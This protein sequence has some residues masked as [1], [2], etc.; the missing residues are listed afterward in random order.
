MAVAAL[1]GDGPGGPVMVT[2][3]SSFVPSVTER[4]KEHSRLI[5]AP[6]QFLKSPSAE[7]SRASY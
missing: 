3:W 7:T 4:Q 6:S 5:A 2:A 1:T